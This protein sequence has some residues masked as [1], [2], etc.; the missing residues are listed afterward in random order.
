MKSHEQC[1]NDLLTRNKL[2]ISSN[3]V[4]NE[5]NYLFQSIE[6]VHTQNIVKLHIIV[7]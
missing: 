6:R 7:I 2:Y 4:E 3:Y 5:G 1:L